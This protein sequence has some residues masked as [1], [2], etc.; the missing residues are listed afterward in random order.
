MTL[1]LI[2]IIAT[3]VVIGVLLVHLAMLNK[4]MG[5]SSDSAISRS[6]SRETFWMVVKHRSSAW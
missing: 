2:L 4:P 5:T 6:C 1:L 3:L